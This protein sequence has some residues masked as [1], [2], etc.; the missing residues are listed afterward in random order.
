MAEAFSAMMLMPLLL[1]YLIDFLPCFQNQYLPS[2]CFPSKYRFFLFRFF[3][4]TF[5]VA[6][7][8]VIAFSLLFVAI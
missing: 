6:A 1:L 4:S 7:V 5:S 3:H 2:L 8:V